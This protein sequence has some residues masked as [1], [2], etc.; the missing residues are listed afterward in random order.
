MF[1]IISQNVRGVFGNVFTERQRGVWVQ[2]RCVLSSILYNV[3]YL[4]GKSE[5]FQRTSAGC[6]GDFSTHKHPPDVTSFTGGKSVF[7]NMILPGIRQG[8]GEMG[9]RRCYLLGPDVSTE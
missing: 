4:G 8:S 7:Y 9:S 1:A 6:L 5:Y 3:N 2:I